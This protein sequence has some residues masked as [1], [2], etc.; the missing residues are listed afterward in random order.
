MLI[1]SSG[2]WWISFRRFA[3][4]RLQHYRERN[5]SQSNHILA[6]EK[7]R[8]YNAHSHHHNERDDKRQEVRPDL[9]H[10]F[11]VLHSK[12]TS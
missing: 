8:Y 7:L 1:G 11:Q 6:N 10:S 3:A 4:Q 12:P 2:R 5:N 9:F